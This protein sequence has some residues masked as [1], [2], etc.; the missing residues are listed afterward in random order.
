MTDQETLEPG[1]APEMNAP[2][3]RMWHVF[4]NG[5][6]LI[7]AVLVLIQMLET[8]WQ[9]VGNPMVWIVSFSYLGLTLLLRLT[10]GELPPEPKVGARWW[11]SACCS[12]FS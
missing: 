12:C 9:P 11:P 7:A 10:A 6:V 5:R 4:L 1:T 3:I 2:F 8:R